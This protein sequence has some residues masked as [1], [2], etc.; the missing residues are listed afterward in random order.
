[1][2]LFKT[3]EAEKKYYKDHAYDVSIEYAEQYKIN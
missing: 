2:L 1:M 3:N